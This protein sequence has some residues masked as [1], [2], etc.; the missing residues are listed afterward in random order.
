MTGIP[1]V[2][3]GIHAWSLPEAPRPIG[4]DPRL[5]SPAAAEVERR[6]TDWEVS[7]LERPGW[8]RVVTPKAKIYGDVEIP[9][10][11]RL[12]AYVEDFG[13]MYAAAGLGDRMAAPYLVRIFRLRRHFCDYAT[14][15]GAANAESLYNPP[16]GEI[17]LWFDEEEVGLSSFEEIVAHEVTHAWMDLAWRRTGPLWFAEGM[18]EYFASFRWEGEIPVP[19]Q[20]KPKIVRLAKLE[21]MPLGRLVTMPRNEM[22]GPEWPRHYALSWSVVH[23][24]MIRVP[25]LVGRL[26]AGKGSIPEP[27]ALDRTWWEYVEAL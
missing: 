19:G 3:E 17:G 15:L 18:A 11:R 25:D 23:Y 9:V 7:Q 1:L 20:V 21:R 6:A 27:E 10:L 5:G 24:L 12:A 8:R 4:H 2:E 22:Y 16:T 14:C 13:A 26:L